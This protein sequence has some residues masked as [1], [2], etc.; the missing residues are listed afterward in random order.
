VWVFYSARPLHIM[1]LLEAV[2]IG[3]STR[4]RGNFSGYKEE[5]VIEACTNLIEVNYGFVRLIH[6]SVKEY[7]TTQQE[8]IIQEGLKEF[9][10]NSTIG[11]TILSHSCLSY[12]FQ[13]FLDA[14]PC[15][16]AESLYLRLQSYQLAS[17]CSYFF[18]SHLCQVSEV[19]GELKKLL[20]RFFSSRST[21]FAAIMQIR[22]L[23]DG[24]VKL[25]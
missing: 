2:Q 23:G 13:G 7:F 24:D 1:E 16:N 21:A 15:R 20:E 25:S 10:V 12:L 5:A 4:K 9:F 22:A 3:E 17:Y 6:Q 18:D 14:G 11:H 8:L 19:P